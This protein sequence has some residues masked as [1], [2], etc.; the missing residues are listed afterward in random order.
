MT[1]G[2][3]QRRGGVLPEADE[4]SMIVLA[5]RLPQIYQADLMGVLRVSP[6]PI[7][8]GVMGA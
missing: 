5:R 4:A 3:L 7:A 2:Q 6:N 1:E 8:L